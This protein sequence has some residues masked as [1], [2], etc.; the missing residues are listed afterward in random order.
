MRET[1][2]SEIERINIIILV[3][4]SFASLAIMRDFQHFFSFA[5]ASSIMTLNFRYLR[6]IM[7]GF[8]SGSALTGVG[9]ASGVPTEASPT[10]SKAELF[11]KLPLKFLVLIALVVIIVLWGNISI[12]FFV[13]GLSTV[14]LSIVISQVAAAFGPVV[15]E[16]K[17]G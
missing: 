15:R 13:I 1:T 10:V 16:R 9:E 6:K 3:L 17:R 7:E 12:L 4:G 8:F 14:F 2:T 5:V 11:I